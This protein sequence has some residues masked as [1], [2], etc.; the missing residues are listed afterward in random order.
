MN[1]CLASYQSVMLLRGGPRTQIQQ[2]GTELE[3][4]G[5]NVTL[6]ES[7]REFQKDKI[8][9]V[10]FFGANIGTYHLAREISHLGIPIA[11]SPIFYSLHNPRFI[12]AALGFNRFIRK[13]FKGFWMD[14]G[15]TADICSWASAVLPNTEREGQ[16]LVDSIGISSDKIIV[17]PNGVDE[18]FYRADKS[19][20][21]EKYNIENF[22]LNVGHIGPRRKNVLNLIRAL[23]GIDVPAVIIGRFENS[24]DGRACLEKA[25]RNPRLLIIDSLPNDSDLLASAYAACDVFALPSLFETPGIAAL[26]AAL[27]GAKIV[28]TKYGGTEE[29]F[30]T[31]AEY[32]DPKSVENIQKGIMTALTKEKNNDLRLHIKEHF[33]WS[34]VAKK[35]LHVYERILTN[36]I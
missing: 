11:V 15:L 28:I 9:L 21:N 29:Y 2:T 17:I 35:T 24:E 31:H 6:F 26:E 34:E 33:L 10:H 18:R 27:T 16:L 36:K 4:L 13:L 1:I 8:D 12:R 32:V 19:V 5:V 20:F 22:I 3:K 14:Y 25:K 23:E 7:W 30:G